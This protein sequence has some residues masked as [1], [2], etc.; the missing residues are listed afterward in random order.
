[1]DDF[2]LNIHFSF[3]VTI[4]MIAVT[5]LVLAALAFT[6]NANELSKDFEVDGEVVTANA[7]DL[8][9]LAGYTNGTGTPNKALVTDSNNAITIDTLNVKNLKVDGFDIHKYK[10]EKYTGSWTGPVTVSN[11]SLIATRFGDTINIYFE[12]FQ[13]TSTTAET[14]TFSEKLAPEFRPVNPI[15]ASIIVLNNSNNTFGSISVATDGTVSLYRDQST[16]GFAATNL[17]GLPFN[18]HATYSHG[19]TY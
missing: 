6:K 8:N 4:F 1:M 17:A 18:T 16:T 19:T 10:E 12:A 5:G 2:P 15:R 7:S 13:D 14:F 9:T 3:S 11:V